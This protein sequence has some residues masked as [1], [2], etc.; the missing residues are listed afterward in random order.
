M[1]FTNASTITSLKKNLY[2]LQPQKKKKK[3]REKKKK[4]KRRR[5]VRKTDH[6]LT[7]APLWTHLW[8][9]C[10]NKSLKTAHL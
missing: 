10:S 2:T 1:E 4:K 3:K 8:T 9:E 5:K 7:E 6:I